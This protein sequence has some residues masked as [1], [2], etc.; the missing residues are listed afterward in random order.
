MDQEYI[1][2]LAEDMCTMLEEA[3]EMG[4]DVD[5]GF[6]QRAF[7]GTSIGIV[8]LFY[9]RQVLSAVPNLPEETMA[10]LGE[11]NVVGLLQEGG[12]ATAVHLL[13]ALDGPFSAVEGPKDMLAAL[14]APGAEAFAEAIKTA[15]RADLD[16]AMNQADDPGH[17]GGHGGG[18]GCGHDH[19]GGHGGGGCGCH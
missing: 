17:G 10:S 9:P 19:G 4:R 3:A 8:Y 15:L 12:Q 16:A 11:S 7:E 18:C 14:Y 6:E 5:A 2:H 13:F 1:N